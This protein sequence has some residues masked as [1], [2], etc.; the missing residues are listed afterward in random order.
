MKEKKKVIRYIIYIP[1]LFFFKRYID[2]LL[3]FLWW[4]VVGVGTKNTTEACAIL[5]Y[6]FDL[7]FYQVCSQLDVQRRNQTNVSDLGIALE[8]CNYV[9]ESKNV[10]DRIYG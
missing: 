9:G 3:K 6:N 4:W 7:M 5:E 8:T 2:K 10:I 1:F